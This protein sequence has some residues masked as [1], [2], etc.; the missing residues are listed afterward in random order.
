MPDTIS[1]Q[2]SPEEKNTVSSCQS[3]FAVS[4]I[5]L[6]EGEGCRELRIN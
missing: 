2:H 6:G 1:L 3:L 5:L 4:A